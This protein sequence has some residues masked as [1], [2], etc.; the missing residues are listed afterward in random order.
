MV[1]R[2]RQSRSEE[3]APDTDQRQV[4]RGDYPGRNGHTSRS[5]LGRALWLI[6]SW[7]ID[8]RPARQHRGIEGDRRRRTNHVAEGDLAETTQGLALTAIRHARADRRPDGRKDNAQSQADRTVVG[9][10]TR[11]PLGM[12]P[13]QTP[14]V[15]ARSRGKSDSGERKV[16]I[17]A[18]LAGPRIPRNRPC[19][20]RPSRFPNPRPPQSYRAP[21]VPQASQKSPAS[22][23]RRPALKQPTPRARSRILRPRA[24]TRCRGNS[25]V[26]ASR[27]GVRRLQWLSRCRRDSP[28]RQLTLEYQPDHRRHNSLAARHPLIHRQH[29]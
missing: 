22:T 1:G 27:R 19:A 11:R 26:R 14:T 2:S 15:T 10:C 6:S 18:A 23:V 7:R 9:R 24:G 17:D 5:R 21:A 16:S 13:V 28:S 25:H 8:R 4:R 29:I 12:F 20:L 3:T